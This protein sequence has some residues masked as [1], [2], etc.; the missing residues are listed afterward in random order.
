MAT[1]KPLDRE[2]TVASAKRTGTVVTV[3]EHSIIGGL[4]SAVAECLTEEYPVPVR[5]IGTRDVFGQSG[6]ADELLAEY[7]LSVDDIVAA[8]EQSVKQK[9]K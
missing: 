1:I 4:G 9:R 3:E 8:A 2:A 7:G 6:E 5:R